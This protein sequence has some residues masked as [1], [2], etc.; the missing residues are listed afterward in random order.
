MIEGVVVSGH[1]AVLVGLRVTVNEG[2]VAAVLLD[3]QVSNDLVLAL[4]VDDI[5]LLVLALSHRPLLDSRNVLGLPGKHV[6]DFVEGRLRGEEGVDV[7]AQ[8]DVVVGFVVLEFGDALLE[9]SYL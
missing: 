6:E 8:D 3:R 9:T 5:A 1:E 4:H 7:S 2:D